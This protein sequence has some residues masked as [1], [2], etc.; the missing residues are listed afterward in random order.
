MADPDW[1]GLLAEGCLDWIDGEY[2]D[3]GEWMSGR[4]VLDEPVSDVEAD[5]NG[6]RATSRSHMFAA[7]QIA[8]WANDPNRR[9]QS[10]PMIQIPPSMRWVSLRLPLVAYERWLSVT[11]PGTYNY[12]DLA[13]LLCDHQIGCQPVGRAMFDARLV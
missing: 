4:W 6:V 5:N 7:Y 8:N 2:N 3:D 12:P 13:G 1:A 11:D 9:S 10:Q